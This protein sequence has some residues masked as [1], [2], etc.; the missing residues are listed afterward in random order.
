ME[1]QERGEARTRADNQHISD[2]NKPSV[3]DLGLTSKQIYEVQ[4]KEQIMHTTENRHNIELLE[5]AFGHVAERAKQ[6]RYP[7]QVV[8]DIALRSA[9]SICLHDLGVK[10]TAHTCQHLA[11]ELTHLAQ[12]IDEAAMARS[13]FKDA[14]A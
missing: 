9:I 2:G 14:A 11:G 5:S 7:A 12:L 13:L 1:A 10:Q 8:A 3:G 6:Q 4:R